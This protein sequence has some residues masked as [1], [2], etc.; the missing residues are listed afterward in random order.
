MINLS[1]WFVL[2]ES[3][4]SEWLGV[5]LGCRI[6]F[7][8]ASH[9]NLSPQLVQTGFPPLPVL[10]RESFLRRSPNGFSMLSPKSAQLVPEASRALASFKQ[11]DGGKV[12]VRFK[13][14]GS[15]P[16]MKQNFFKITA[17]NRFQT[18]IAFLRKELALKPA[19]PVFLYVNSSFSPAPDETVS[20]LFKCFS[21][22]GHLIVNYRSARH[23]PGVD[24]LLFSLYLPLFTSLQCSFK[25][26]TYLDLSL[27]KILGITKR[28]IFEFK[29]TSWNTMS[30]SRR[31]LKW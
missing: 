18:V 6:S 8:G 23:L 4:T 28:N 1:I 15:A 30:F 9:P 14:T 17:S 11:N 3:I 12:V 27:S 19:D 20:N 13:A 2:R 29:L 24:Q 26:Y 25:S 10:S 31:S 21:T 16:I 22:D 7:Q 5:N